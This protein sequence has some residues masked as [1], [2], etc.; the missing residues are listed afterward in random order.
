MLKR[1]CKS[2]L[3]SFPDLCMGFLAKDVICSLNQRSPF[4]RNYVNYA[5]VFSIFINFGFVGGFFVGFFLG[6]GLL[7]FLFKEV[8]SCLICSEKIVF[9]QWLSGSCKLGSLAKLC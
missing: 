5:D 2:D 6:G 7:L 1:L 3:K 9:Q 8:S 4:N